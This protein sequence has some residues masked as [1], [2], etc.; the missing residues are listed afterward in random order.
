MKLVIYNGKIIVDSN[1]LPITIE[2]DGF[3]NPIVV[4]SESELNSYTNSQYNG[5]VVKYGEDYYVINNNSRELI[6]T[7][8]TKTLL[9]S[10]F[11]KGWNFNIGSCPG[12]DGE[13]IDFKNTQYI[14]LGFADNSN[15]DENAVVKYFLMKSLDGTTFERSCLCNMKTVGTTQEAAHKFILK[16]KAN[17]IY[18]FE[19]Y[20]ALG[21]LFIKLPCLAEQGDVI[22]E[23][24]VV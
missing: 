20:R 24:W 7:N 12:P 19:I 2:D 6:S 8:T 3:E 4:Y 17:V 9:L 21:E 22:R 16:E 14:L 5:A 15:L 1:G 13:S 11:W 18:D 10:L 23:I